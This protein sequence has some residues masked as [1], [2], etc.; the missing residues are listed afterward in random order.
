MP[1]VL[2]SWIALRHGLRAA[3][4][5]C[6]F[7]AAGAMAGGAAVWLWSE[8]RPAQASSIIERVPAI[9]A[10]AVARARDSIDHGP[11]VLTALAGAVSNRPFKLYAAAAP[12]AGI[13][14]PAFVAAT[15]LIRLPRFLLVSLAFAGLG[16]VLRRRLPPRAATVLFAAGWTLFYAAF[17][18]LSP[19]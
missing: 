13:A 16:A 9:P 2:L 7:A 10:G 6:L 3:V 8:A 11:W 5:A 14:L 12:H 15:P 18:L 4:L 19:W 1:D 17:W